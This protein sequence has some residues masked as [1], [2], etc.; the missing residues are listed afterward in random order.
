M[1]ADAYKGVAPCGCNSPWTSAKQQPPQNSSET[2]M[3]CLGI[4][5]QCYLLCTAQTWPCLHFPNTVLRWT[6]PVCLLFGTTKQ[7]PCLHDTHLSKQCSSQG[8]TCIQ[9]ATYLA[10]WLSFRQSKAAFKTRSFAAGRFVPDSMAPT[11]PNINIV[12]LTR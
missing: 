11:K 12:A 4:G 3:P 2:I 1:E 5:H 10:I 9:S 8:H 6:P 7:R